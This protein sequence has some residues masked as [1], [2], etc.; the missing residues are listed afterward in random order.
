VGICIRWRNEAGGA[1]V[2]VTVVAL[3][4]RGFWGGVL[5]GV[6]AGYGG[7]EAGCAGGDAGAATGVV[8]FV[9]LAYATA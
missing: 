3:G 8:G 5:F 9:V 1:A 2:T 6:S 7:V 4:V